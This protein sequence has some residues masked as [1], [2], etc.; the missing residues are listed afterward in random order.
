LALTFQVLVVTFQ[1]IGGLVTFLLLKIHRGKNFISYGDM[2]I[3]TTC[4][5]G[6]VGKFYV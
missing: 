6:F 3:D 2:W 4:F 5:S 1:L